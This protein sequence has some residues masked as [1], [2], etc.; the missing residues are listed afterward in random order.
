MRYRADGHKRMRYAVK[1]K[2]KG[3]RW[4]CGPVAMHPRRSVHITSLAVGVDEVPPHRASVEV[5]VGRGPPV[6]IETDFPSHRIT[7]LNVNDTRIPL[8]ESEPG[9]WTD[10]GQTIRK[11][12][13]P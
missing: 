1:T 5:R 13:K 6:F 12:G 8:R 2:F 10:D 4:V 9:V 7:F 3:W 11:L